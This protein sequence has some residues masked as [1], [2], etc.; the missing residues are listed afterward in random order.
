MVHSHTFLTSAR[1][2]YDTW[3]PERWGGSLSAIVQWKCVNCTH[4]C[5]LC[6]AFVRRKILRQLSARSL[7]TYLGAWICLN[8]VPESHSEPQKYQCGHVSPPPFSIHWYSKFSDMGKLVWAYVSN[9]W[10]VRSITTKQAF[11]FLRRPGKTCVPQIG[12]VPRKNGIFYF[13]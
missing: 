10:A 8:V 4:W 2:T 3:L 9:L 13:M 7:E 12:V 6:S 5:Y 1:E 11:R